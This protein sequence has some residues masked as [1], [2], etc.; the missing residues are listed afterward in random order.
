V[1]ARSQ[2]KRLWLAGGSGVAL[3][4]ALIG[5]QAGI[6][7][8]LSS[9]RSLRAEMSTV[10]AQ[11]SDLQRKL[12]ALKVANDNVAQLSA[13]LRIALAALPFDSGLPAF[14]RQVSSQATQSQV[15]LASVTVGPISPAAATA[16]AGSAAT[17][18]A[19]T[20]TALVAIPITLVTTGSAKGQLAFLTAL[21]VTG[22]RR[23]LV[24]SVTL[25]AGSGP[26]TSSIDRSST[27]TTQLATFS[28]PLTA[29]AQA[30]LEKLLSS[31]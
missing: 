11:N 28:A 16:V 30:A 7:P 12:A 31:N 4:I 1:N 13:S 15:I 29:T 14:T 18:T 2:D 27:M 6:G 5:W 8:Q 17:G 24:T 25:G 21:Q 3:V 10:Q 23:A 26:S 19:A 22:P 9:T 20:G